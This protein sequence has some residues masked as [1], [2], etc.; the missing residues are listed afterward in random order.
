MKI[1]KNFSLNGKWE[2][3]DWASLCLSGSDVMTFLQGQMTN[4][5]GKLCDEMGQISCRL[6]R[7]GRIQ[8]YAFVSKKNNKFEIIGP[9]KVLELLANDLKRYIIMEDVILSEVTPKAMTII[10]GESSYGLISKANSCFFDFFGIPAVIKGHEDASGIASVPEEDYLDFLL[11]TG[12]KQLDEKICGHLINET[13]FNNYAISYKK[14]CFLGQ[15]TSAKIENNK[16]AGNFPCIIALDHQQN[17]RML[18]YTKQGKGKI[19]HDKEGVGSLLGVSRSRDFSLAKITRRFRADGLEINFEIEDE[20]FSGVIFNLP[21]FSCQVAASRRVENIDEVVFNWALDAFHKDFNDAAVS[22]CKIGL[23]S[24][25]K[26]EAIWEVL[27]VIY[28][29]LGEYDNGLSCMDRLLDLDNKSI[30]AHTNKSLFYMKMGRIDEA[31][32][33][34]A[35]AT[36]A[37]FKLNEQEYKISKEQSEAIKKREDMFREVLT[38]DPEDQMALFGLTEILLDAERISDLREISKSLNHLYPADERSLFVKG[39]VL[40]SQLD[41]QAAK[42]CYEEALA[43]AARKANAKWINR[44]KKEID[45]LA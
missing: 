23:N 33:E 18:K 36:V 39:K 30:M 44:I 24:N 40:L 43:I 15:E 1:E 10:F 34:K 4:D 17:E 12:I 20:S 21:Y 25:H 2:L 29:R 45:N 5:I 9:C 28:G 11:G 14:G 13:I 19:I 32:E 41:T 3:K 35:L 22:L 26:N 37:S 8:S 27:G 16:G 6:D 7:T 31:E 42:S 38:I